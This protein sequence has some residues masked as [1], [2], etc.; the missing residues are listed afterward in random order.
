L[1]L[2][3]QKQKEKKKQRHILFP[4][5]VSL[6]PSPPVV[7]IFT[8]QLPAFE[9]KRYCDFCWKDKEEEKERKNK[10]KNKR[11]DRFFISFVVS[12]WHELRHLPF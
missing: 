11:A 7:M 4:V 9:R 6:A 12:A 2:S 10:E 5:C 1:L 3:K 8:V